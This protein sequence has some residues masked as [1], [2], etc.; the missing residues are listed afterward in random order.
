VDSKSVKRTGQILVTLRQFPS[1]E[2]HHLEDLSSSLLLL[3]K[4]KLAGNLALKK[5]RQSFEYIYR[6]VAIKQT[7]K[8]E[9]NTFVIKF[10]FRYEL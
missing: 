3:C 8:I 5:V 9:L 6:S 7:K 4:V 2:V 1:T 10:V